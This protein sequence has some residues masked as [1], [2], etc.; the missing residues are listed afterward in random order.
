M[1]YVI[2]HHYNDPRKHFIAYKVPKYI[3]GSNSENVIFEFKVG[4]KVKRKW[5]PKQEIILLTDNET[6][7]NKT[8][9]QLTRVQEEHL[10]HV[11]SAEKELQS[12]FQ[13]MAASM[14]YEFDALETRKKNPSDFPSLV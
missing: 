9:A 7:F 13:K 11:K 4:G 2:Q 10:A 3:T 1:Y 12:A 14:Q 5:A 6:L 8:V